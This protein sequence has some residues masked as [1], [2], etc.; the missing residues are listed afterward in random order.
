MRRTLFALLAALAAT[1]AAWLPS[2]AQISDPDGDADIPCIDIVSL[3]VRGDTK[4]LNV[5]LEMSKR[6]YPPEYVMKGVDLETPH[7]CPDG[8]YHLAIDLT[9]AG[10]KTVIVRTRFDRRL[11]PSSSGPDGLTVRTDLNS[12]VINWQIPVRS[13]GV[14]ALPATVGL[15]VAAELESLRSFRPQSGALIISDAA[16]DSTIRFRIGVD[17]S[18]LIGPAGGVVAVS[19]TTSPIHATELI[20]PPGALAEPTCIEL[21]AP[22]APPLPPVGTSLRTP[23]VELGPS[24]LEPRHP[25]ELHLPILPHRDTEGDS[26][27]GYDLSVHGSA[28]ARPL[29]LVLALYDKLVVAVTNFSVIGGAARNQLGVLRS[30]AS[31]SILAGPRTYDSASHEL[32][33]RCALAGP[34]GV[35]RIL[36]NAGE[37]DEQG[38]LSP[39]HSNESLSIAVAGLLLAAPE[40]TARLWINGHTSLLGSSAGIQNGPTA[41]AELLVNTIDRVV[42]V[43]AERGQPLSRGEVTARVGVFLDIEPDKM[44]SESHGTF[45]SFAYRMFLLAVGN[46]LESHGAG[47]SA[48][49][50]Y[51]M[52]LSTC[53]G[54]IGPWSWS[55][56]TFQSLLLDVIDELYYPPYDYGTEWGC[57]Q[58]RS[59]CEQSRNCYSSRI[60]TD[61]ERLAYLGLSEKTVLLLN[62][63]Q[64]TKT[65]TAAESIEA[66]VRGILG[67]PHVTSLAGAS[68][69]EIQAE[70]A[71]PEGSLFDELNVWWPR[72]AEFVEE[73]WPNCEY[74]ADSRPKYRVG[75]LQRCGGGDPTEGEWA[76]IRSAFDGGRP[77]WSCE[78]PEA[79]APPWCTS[80]ALTFVGNTLPNG[81]RPLVCQLSP[82]GDQQ[83]S[84]DRGPVSGR[85]RAVLR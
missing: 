74:D 10:G 53:D 23:A 18:A 6:P 12:G 84:A 75:E 71:P 49:G 22:S 54:N 32:Y 20:L 34:N 17:G 59:L 42:A 85:S 7:L 16:G 60:A 46:A 77:E 76:A 83:F 82:E 15:R 79:F 38:R 25:A 33:S 37:L 45:P 11:Q 62:A 58:Y 30:N 19:D 57:T 36:F 56:D 78:S 48:L 2:I 3:D 43:T 8:D 39:A 66:G 31:F 81:W 47:E 61:I 21:R 70:A 41:T 28:S 50:I 67:A 5:T 69:Y 40:A 68:L 35:D 52:R 44:L 55:D 13:L 65:H 63:I 4:N 9:A 27:V 73:S 29:P 1:A 26:I 24:G 80:T 14:A 51:S 72:D 64:Y